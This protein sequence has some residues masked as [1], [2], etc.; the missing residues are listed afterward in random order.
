M[1][2]HSDV[3]DNGLAYIQ[4][5]ATRLHLIN[6]YTNGDSYATVVAASVCEVII[7]SA[8]F[9]LDTP[10]ATSNRRITLAAQSGVAD[11][12]ASGTPPLYYAIVDATNSKVLWVTDESNNPA[13]VAVDDPVEF[14]A[15]SHT[16]QQPV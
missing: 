7:D 1:W 3:L 2:V 5:N 14:A 4:A 11:G 10:A 13:A 9:T 16:S 15:V 8:D 6:G 12:T